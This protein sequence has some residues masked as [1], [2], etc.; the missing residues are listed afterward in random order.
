MTNVNV[1]DFDRKVE[2]LKSALDKYLN[3][4]KDLVIIEYP[5]PNIGTSFEI[6]NSYKT[7]T[8]DQTLTIPL[9]SSA[10]LIDSCVKTVAKLLAD[11]L[12]FDNFKNINGI[13][14]FC[15]VDLQTPKHKYATVFRSHGISFRY[16]EID[17][18]GRID[19]TFGYT[20]EPIEI[21]VNNNKYNIHKDKK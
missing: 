11:K 3:P 10:L 17:G 20:V 19:T 6:P 21:L 12:S 14:Y 8:I 13:V 2:N 15:S 4:M 9:S 5:A 16:M 18:C 7:L 1:T